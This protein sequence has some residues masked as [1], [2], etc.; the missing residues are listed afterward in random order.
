MAQESE[1]GAGYQL[2]GMGW[3]GRWEGVPKGRGCKYNL[4][5]IHAEV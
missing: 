3:R 2:T 1:T 4:G 5:L